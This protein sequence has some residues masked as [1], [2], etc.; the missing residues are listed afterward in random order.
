[1]KIVVEN[2]DIKTILFSG[3]C[4]RAILE[5]DGSVTNVL[6][7]RVVNIKQDNNILYVK[8]SNYDKLEEIIIDYFNFK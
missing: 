2:V 6:K 3:A 1:M 5:S 4:F 7:D 8:S